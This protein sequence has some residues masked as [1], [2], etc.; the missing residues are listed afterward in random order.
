MDQSGLWGFWGS[1]LWTLGG[2]GDGEVWVWIVGSLSALR[3]GLWTLQMRVWD[4]F[5]FFEKGYWGW[6]LL[7]L[8]LGLDLGLL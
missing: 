4:L 7:G 2:S 5:S 8:G 6:A 3:L 1:G